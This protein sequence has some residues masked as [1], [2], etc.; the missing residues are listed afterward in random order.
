[1]SGL[2]GRSLRVITGIHSQQ[3]VIVLTG[4]I[5]FDHELR[6]EVSNSRRL[7]RMNEPIFV[8]GN[9]LSVMT[10]QTRYHCH[11]HHSHPLPPYCAMGELHQSISC[12]STSSPGVKS[13]L[14]SKQD[15]HILHDIMIED[16]QSFFQLP[17]AVDPSPPIFATANKQ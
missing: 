5:R 8:F 1:M 2:C 17:C 4:G 14:A 15:G 3:K 13:P 12:S 16:D 10:L 11:A 6:C 9:S 7:L